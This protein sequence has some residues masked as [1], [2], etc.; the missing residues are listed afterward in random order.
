MSVLP[1]RMKQLYLTSLHQRVV[2]Q[3]RMIRKAAALRTAATD[4]ASDMY[5]LSVCF[6]SQSDAIYPDRLILVFRNSSKKYQVK[7]YV[8]QRQLF[9]QYLQVKTRFNFMI[10]SNRIPI[11]TTSVNKL[12]IDLNNITFDEFSRVERS[13]V[14]TCC[15]FV[16]RRLPEEKVKIRKTLVSLQQCRETCV[17][18]TLIIILIEVVHSKDPEDSK[19]W[20]LSKNK[21]YLH[22]YSTPLT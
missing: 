1:L 2:I 13:T 7:L 3:H 18:F 5:S 8:R 22:I 17:T 11:L 6:E 12:L 16:S 14:L 20:V 4:K 9:P 15:K 10:W 21:V 19:S